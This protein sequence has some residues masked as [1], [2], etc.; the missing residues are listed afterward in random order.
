M[1]CTDYYG[2]C[3]EQQIGSTRAVEAGANDFVSKPIDKLELKVRVASMLKMKEAQ[4]AIKRHRAELEETVER[5]PAELCETENVFG[6]C[7]RPPTILFS[8]K[9]PI[10]GIRT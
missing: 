9:T 8:S 5:R 7:S 3:T 4:D 1:R 2:D 10:S 6:Q